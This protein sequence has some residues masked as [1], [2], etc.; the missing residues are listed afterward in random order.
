MERSVDDLAFS[1][2]RTEPEFTVRDRA[3]G[4]ERRR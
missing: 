2:E 3:R 1:R 4:K